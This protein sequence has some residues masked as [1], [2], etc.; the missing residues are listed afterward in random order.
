MI[1][2]MLSST[3]YE[4]ISAVIAAASGSADCDGC[5]CPD[6][7]QAVALDTATHN[8]MATARE[9]QNAPLPLGM[10]ELSSHIHRHRKN[11]QLDRLAHVWPDVA[12]TRHR[13]I[14][15]RKPANAS[16]P[17]ARAA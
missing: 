2:R 12:S 11:R 13:S 14:R 10:K 17:S 5:G 6:D 3:A 7:E 15:R 16:S 4:S 1:A 9:P 8:P